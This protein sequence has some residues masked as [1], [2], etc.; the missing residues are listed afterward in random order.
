MNAID[1]AIK[2]EVANNP[3]VREIDR[4]RQREL[5]ASVGLLVVVV[6]AALF[7]SWQHARFLVYGYQTEALRQELAL[8][9]Q[10][11]ERLR[12]EL[13]TLQAPRLIEERAT[14]ELG[15]VRPGPDQFQVI[16]RVVPSEA[17]SSSVVASR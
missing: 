9:R 1:Y 7:L 15:L 2:R 11:S 10:L 12:L 14:R 5:W 4:A 16:P 3:I 8:K 6:A 13:E 17:P